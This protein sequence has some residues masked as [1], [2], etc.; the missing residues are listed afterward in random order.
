MAARSTGARRS[1]DKTMDNHEA[2]QSY[3][4]RV[5]RQ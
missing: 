2:Y 5:E 3:P 1:T 4:K